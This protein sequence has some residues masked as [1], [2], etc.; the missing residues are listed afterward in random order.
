MPSKQLSG[1]NTIAIIDENVAE[2]VSEDTSTESWVQAHV[3]IPGKLIDSA[4]EKGNQESY[5]ESS[6]YVIKPTYQD[7]PFAFLFILHFIIFLSVGIR[8]GSWSSLTALYENAN[9]NTEEDEDADADADA[10][11]SDDGLS[12]NLP[13]I[14]PASSIALS[15][16]ISYF[17]TTLLLSKYP[18]QAVTGSLYG[19]FFTYLAFAGIIFFSHPS[20]WTFLIATFLIYISI[21]YITSVRIFIPFASA[22]LQ[23][24]TD[25]LSYN[26]FIYLVSLILGLCNFIWIAFWTYTVSGL[27]I[28]DQEVKDDNEKQQHNDDYYYSNVDVVLG[29]KFFAILL[30]L[31]WTANIFTNITQTTTAGITGIFCFDKHSCGFFAVHQSLLRSITYSF[32]SICFG[33]LLNAIVTALRVMTRYAQENARNRDQNAMA[34]IY[35]LLQ[36]ILSLLEDIIEYFNQWA[37]I[38]VG[39]YGTSY[40]ES[41]KNVLQLFKARGVEAI[42]SNG[43]IS[44]VLMNVVIAS[45]LGCGLFG[46]IM[47]RTV[48]TFWICFVIGLL[49]SSIMMYTVQGAVK[50]VIVCYAD[51]P[52]RLHENHPE[53]TTRLT[54]AISMVFPQVPVPVWNDMTV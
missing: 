1:Y 41:G 24:A 26:S 54:K 8:Y 32:G 53:G 6:S 38:F 31:Y 49:V 28:F 51:H 13:F 43:L 30:S 25:A 17:T 22:N 18:T 47:D 20:I 21:W 46:Y 10:S 50:A 35:C 15:Y 9:T 33:S 42:I 3:I 39:I 52:S 11:K 29:V 23:L 16:V 34:L 37:Y 40:L 2:V 27:G 5:E 44:Y 45:S 4:V 14:I 12:W 36:C 7:K 48:G 19:S